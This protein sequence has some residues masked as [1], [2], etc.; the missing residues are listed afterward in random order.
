MS[1][2]RYSPVLILIAAAVMAYGVYELENPAWLHGGPPEPYD[3]V[4][5]IAVD[6]ANPDIIY[7]GIGRYYDGRYGGVFKST[8]GGKSWEDLR[9]PENTIFTISGNPRNDSIVYAGGGRLYRSPDRGR[10]WVLIEDVPPGIRSIAVDPATGAVYVGCL[11]DEL[12]WRE[13]QQYPCFFRSTDSG[14]T[15]ESIELPGTYVPTSIT[16][17]AIS[18]GVIYAGGRGLY[19]S[20]D[21]GKSWMLLEGAPH[22]IRAVAVSAVN[23]DMVYAATPDSLFKSSDGGATWEEVTVPLSGTVISTVAL[24]P[25]N[26]K[27]IYVGTLPETA[28]GCQGVLKS[29]DGG[30]SWEEMNKGLRGCGARS[31][32]TIEISA[33]MIY[34]GTYEGIFYR[35]VE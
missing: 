21:G 7:A 12:G 13:G 27:V 35:K 34:I 25:S 31:I 10:S 15:W 32:N 11:Y 17:I 29:S 22:D 28:R 19:K 6:P 24:N 26:A 2:R 3:D 20:T 16:S 4:F 14:I 9:A 5:A 23:P 8:D 33:G 1:D 30:S 18:K